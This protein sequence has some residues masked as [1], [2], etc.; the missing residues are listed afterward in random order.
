MVQ[1]GQQGVQLGNHRVYLVFDL[2]GDHFHIRAR[3]QRQIGV[4]AQRWRAGVAGFNADKAVANQPFFAQP[5]QR[6]LA[7]EFQVAVFN[8]RHHV[9]MGVVFRVML[10]TA[11]ILKA[12]NF[13][14]MPGFRS[15]PEAAYRRMGVLAQT[16]LA[17]TAVR[18]QRGQ[19]KHGQRNKP[20]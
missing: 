18:Q 2:L 5:G 3:H 1:P 12:R 7:D 16:S 17:A 9:H 4:F 19:A 20:P 13:T 15:L 14:G 11:P 6:G 10:W 8:A